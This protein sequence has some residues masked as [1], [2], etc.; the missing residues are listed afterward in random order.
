[1]FLAAVP[2]LLYVL[3]IPGGFL[4]VAVLLSYGLYRALGKVFPG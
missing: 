1:M 2:N 4:L 3:G